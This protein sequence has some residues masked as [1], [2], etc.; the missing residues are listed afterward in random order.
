MH[1]QAQKKVYKRFELYK[2][3]VK[4][5]GEREWPPTAEIPNSKSH[6]CANAG[7][8]VYPKYIHTIKKQNVDEESKN[9]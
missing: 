3:N 9:D 4:A 7:E 1:Q 2:L 5:C 6:P 8:T